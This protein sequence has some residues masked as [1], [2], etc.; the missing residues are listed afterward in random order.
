MQKMLASKARQYDIWVAGG[1]IPIKTQDPKV[2]ETALLLNPQEYAHAWRTKH[3]NPFG[4]L[5]AT[6]TS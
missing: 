4:S 2:D 5:G 3:P 1:S 6:V